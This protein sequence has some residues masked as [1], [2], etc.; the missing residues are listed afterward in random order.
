MP[1]RAL[2]LALPL[3]PLASPP[4]LLPLLPAPPTGAGREEEGV[5]VGEGVAL[6]L[7]PVDTLAVGVGVALREAMGARRK[8]TQ[9]LQEAS[10]RYTSAGRAVAGGVRSPTPSLPPW[11][12][13]RA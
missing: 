4:P 1:H 5:G 8:G 11:A 9:R 10:P 13:G 12:Q 6:G 2:L 7:A 3:L